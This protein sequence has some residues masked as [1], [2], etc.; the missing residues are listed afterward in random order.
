MVSST[1]TSGFISSESQIA[2]G[3]ITNSSI[4]A[5]AAIAKSKL[6]ALNIASADVAAGSAILKDYARGQAVFTA[7]GGWATAP[8]GTLGNITDG[9][10]TTK[11]TTTGIINGGAAEQTLVLTSLFAEPDS[12]LL[13][14]RVKMGAFKTSAGAATVQCGI[15]WGAL[16]SGN[17]VSTTSTTEVTATLTFSIG[18][19]AINA[20]TNQITNA[21]SGNYG[22]WCSNSDAAI[23]SNFNFYTL[24]GWGITR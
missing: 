16:D 11:Q 15:R 22:F 7:S 4:S 6:A 19:G 23:A 12:E 21:G 9:D 1:T 2:A 8:S 17:V 3:I 10:D 24:E 18:Q 14:V 13:F 5:S 20:F